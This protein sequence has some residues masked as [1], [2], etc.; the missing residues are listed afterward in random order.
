[1][2][3]K[4]I[5]WL[6]YYGYG[7]KYLSVYKPN[8]YECDTLWALGLDA[9]VGSWFLSSF[10]PFL[11]ILYTTPLFSILTL[12][13][14]YGVDASWQ[15]LLNVPIIQTFLVI[16]WSYLYEILSIMLYSI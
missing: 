12:K 5:A 15:F 11:F 3:I 16:P 8:I 7:S 2:T 4:T 6:P 13:F 14:A 1:M 10:I 9:A